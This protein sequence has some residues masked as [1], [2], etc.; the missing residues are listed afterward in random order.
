MK[1]LLLSA[2]ALLLAPGAIYSVDEPPLKEGFWT[3]RTQM[4]QNPGNTKEDTTRSVCRNHA[5]DAYTRSTAKKTNCK[6]I[7]ESTSGTTTTT[8]SECKVNDIVIRNKGTLTVTGD[9]AT[10]SEAHTTSTPPA[11]GVSESTMIV[12]EKYVGACPAGVGPGD[13]VAADGKV[14]HTWQP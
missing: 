8:D 2:A 13:I 11:R 7:S 10:R 14:L 9:T 5:Y 12:E 4:T 6:T 3:I 1:N